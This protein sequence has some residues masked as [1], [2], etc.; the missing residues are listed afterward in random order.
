MQY[1]NKIHLYLK[2]YSLRVICYAVL[3][4]ALSKCIF[5]KGYLKHENKTKALTALFCQGVIKGFEWNHLQY[6]YS[7]AQKCC[8]RSSLGL[9]TQSIFLYGGEVK[10]CEVRSSSFPTQIKLFITV[11]LAWMV[12]CWCSSIITFFFSPFFYLIICMTPTLVCLL[13]LF[14]FSSFLPLFHP[15]KENRKMWWESWNVCVCVRACISKTSP[16]KPRHPVNVILQ[17]K[18]SELQRKHERDAT[19]RMTKHVWLLVCTC[20]SAAVR[21][22]CMKSCSLLLY[23]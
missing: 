14:L 20:V 12:I 15:K 6:L 13:L 22:V 21:R 2:M 3:Y 17:K 11:W 10:G 19:E 1:N 23:C 18:Q 8:W 5:F 9:E 16:S 7:I 4:V